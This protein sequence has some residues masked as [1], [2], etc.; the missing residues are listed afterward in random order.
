MKGEQTRGETYYWLS[1]EIIIENGS[2]DTD[3]M[4]L[5]QGKITITPIHYD[6]TCVRELERLRGLKPPRIKK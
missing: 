4:A 2:P 1:G 5:R 6:L 3:S